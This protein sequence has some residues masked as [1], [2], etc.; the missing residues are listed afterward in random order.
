MLSQMP[1]SAVLPAQDIKRAV[2]FYQDKLGLKVKD[3]GPNGETSLEAGRGTTILLYE[4]PAVKVEHTQAGFWVKD[5]E[6]EM[7]E[8][9]GKGVVFEEYDFPG[10]KTVNGV[11][12]EGEVKSAW[13]KD[14]EGNILALT[15]M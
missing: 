11:A 7:K 14:T 3:T 12:T 5:L 10:L 15:Q 6:A 13:L 4:R 1:V 8:L 2:K 9:R